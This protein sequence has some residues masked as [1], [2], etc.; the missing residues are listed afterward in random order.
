MALKTP[1]KKIFLSMWFFDGTRG[2][3]YEI[4]VFTR[5]TFF[6]LYRLDLHFPF[7]DS[8]HHNST[9]FLAGS[10]IF[11][12]STYGTFQSGIGIEVIG[13][14]RRPLDDSFILAGALSIMLFV[15]IAIQTRLRTRPNME[16]P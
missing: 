13:E 6:N 12:V 10:N 1:L 4:Y 5:N 16:K 7:F 14:G 11:V 2:A 9:S 15:A 8:S 3:D